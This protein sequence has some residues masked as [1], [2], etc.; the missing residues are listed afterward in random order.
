MASR[1]A[2]FSELGWYSTRSTIYSTKLFHGRLMRRAATPVTTA[3][4]EVR[5][6]QVQA[7]ATGPSFLSATKDL[8]EL[9]GLSQFWALSKF[10]S[11][12]VWTAECKQALHDNDVRLWQNMDVQT[13][14]FTSCQTSGVSRGT[15]PK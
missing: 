5:L 11:K 3:L 4:L 15:R 9:L 8:L 1:W 2:V 6:R 7:D 13:G 14:D 10:S 12:A